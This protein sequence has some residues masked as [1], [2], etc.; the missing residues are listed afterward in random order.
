MSLLAVPQYLR[1]IRLLQKEQAIRMI[2]VY[3]V[4]CFFLLRHDVRSISY[5]NIFIV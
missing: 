3:K 2:N 1:Q 4:A 5:I